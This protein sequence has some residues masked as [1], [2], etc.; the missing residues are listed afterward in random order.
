MKFQSFLLFF[1]FSIF[2]MRTSWIFSSVWTTEEDEKLKSG[3]QQIGTKNWTKV[4]DFI[5]G[6]TNKQCRER[7]TNHLDPT[8]DKSALSKKE[9]QLLEELMPQYTIKKENGGFRTSWT[10]ITNFFVE[11]DSQGCVIRRRTDLI[12]RNYYSAI[13]KKKKRRKQFNIREKKKQKFMDSE[14]LGI[15]FG[16]TEELPI[17]FLEST[18]TSPD[19]NREDNSDSEEFNLWRV[20]PFDIGSEELLQEEERVDIPENDFFLLLL[21][22]TGF[23]RP[24]DSDS[25]ST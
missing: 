4:A 16:D 17:S 21:R 14:T 2:F 23:S 15:A 9:H 11:R 19:C 18:S 3:V 22:S 25:Q 6:K 8:I 7:Y 1:L 10:E 24:S 5:P 13:E 20:S 12:L